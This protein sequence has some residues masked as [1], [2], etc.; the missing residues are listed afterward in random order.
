M[1]INGV[2]LLFALMACK[3]IE[4]SLPEFSIQNRDKIEPEVSRL[5]VDVEVNMNQMFEEAEKSTP[6]LFHGTSAS[7]EGISYTYVFSRKPISFS[8]SPLQLETK[9]EGGFSLDLSYCPLCI[10]LWNGKESCTVPRIYASCGLNEKERGYTMRYLT[11]LGLSKDYR[12]TAKTELEEF[13]IKDPCELT[14]LNYD[15]QKSLIYQNDH[16]DESF[17]L[18]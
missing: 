12:L 3:T 7:C 9:I 13:T 1:F 18:K 4:P 8:T 14:F 6:L 17:L 16:Q 2:L 15:V 10:T 5:N 11:T